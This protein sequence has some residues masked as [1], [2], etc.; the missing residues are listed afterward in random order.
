MKKLFA[1][2][3]L[4]LIFAA[5]LEAQAP[6][7]FSG[8]EGQGVTTLTSPPDSFVAVTGNPGEFKVTLIGGNGV[9]QPVNVS[10]TGKLVLNAW[11]KL[12]SADTLRVKYRIARKPTAYP[13]SW[14]GLIILANSKDTSATGVFCAVTATSWNV[15]WIDFCVGRYT[16]TATPFEFPNAA[17][18]AQFTPWAV[19]DTVELW[20]MGDS[21]EGR[22][23]GVKKM[24]W[25]DSR[26]ASSLAGGAYV[27]IGARTQST[28]FAFDDLTI[29]RPGSQAP[30]P[31]VRDLYGPKGAVS[32]SPTGS[33][34]GK[35]FTFN[36]SATDS[37]GF[38]KAWLYLDST[39]SRS[40]F[41]LLDSTSIQAGG[42]KTYGA[43]FARAIKFLTAGNKYIYAKLQDDTLNVSY[44]DTV[45]IAV[46]NATA[47]T[48]LYVSAY[49]PVWGI[50]Q[51]APSLVDFSYINDVIYFAA[52]VDTSTAPYFG[53]VTRPNDS[54]YMVWGG[55]T[56]NCGSLAYPATPSNPPLKQLIDAVHAAGNKFTLC[57]GGIY[58]ADAG[59]MNYLFADSAKTEAW[60][61]SVAAFC[62][63]WN[64]DGANVDLEHPTNGPNYMRGLRILRRRLNAVIPN[65]RLTIAMG[66]WNDASA[67]RPYGSYDLLNSYIDNAQMMTYDFMSGSTAW[68]N[69]P[70][71]DAPNEYPATLNY[72]S[73]EN[74]NPT[75]NVKTGG[76][77]GQYGWI[78]DGFPAAK[79]SLGIPFY[80]WVAGGGTDLPKKPGDLR[81]GNIFTYG[82]YAEVLTQLAAHP[83]GYHW[84][85]EAGVPFLQYQGT[86][87]RLGGS[88]VSQ[89]YISYDDPQ[90]IPLKVKW[91]A[92]SAI[93]GVFIYNLYDG[94]VNSAPAGQKQPLSDAVKAAVGGGIVPVIPGTAVLLSPSG[95]GID[96]LS[97][98]YKW[99]KATNA[100]SYTLE[101]SSSSAFSAGTVTVFGATTDT[102]LI[103]NAN[104]LGYGQVRYW[105]VTS[106]S[107]TGHASISSASSFTTANLTLSTPLPPTLLKPTANAT[108]ANTTDSLKWS[109]VDSA[110]SYTLQVR[111]GDSTTGAQWTY[112]PA[113][114][115]T[116]YL[117]SNLSNSTVYYWRVS[118]ENANGSSGYTAFRKFTTKAI[119]QDTT[120]RAKGTRNEF[121]AMAAAA[122]DFRTSTALRSQLTLRELSSP[123]QLVAPFTP[124]TYNFGLVGSTFYKRGYDS[125]AV[126]IGSLGGP[127]ALVTGVNAPLSVTNG[128]LSIDQA[129]MKE[130]IAA[131]AN[132]TVTKTTAVNGQ[133]TYT[134]GTTGAATTLGGKSLGQV[135]DS[136][137]VGMNSGG[138]PSLSTWSGFHD[139]LIHHI[140]AIN[141]TTST[142]AG[143]LG[144]M[145][146]N[147]QAVGSGAAGTYG[148]WGNPD[149]GLAD[150]N[151]F[152][153]LYVLSDSNNMADRTKAKGLTYRI[154]SNTGQGASP[155][156]DFGSAL[157]VGW[158]FRVGMLTPST[159][160]S[161]VSI[162]GISQGDVNG[163]NRGVATPDTNVVQIMLEWGNKAATGADSIY[164]VTCDGTNK[165]RQGICIQAASTWY[166]A[167]FT[168][169]RTSVT[170]N[171]YTI[172][173]NVATLAG[174]KTLTTNLPAISAGA[175][176]VF[177]TLTYS[178]DHYSKVT[179]WDYVEYYGAVVR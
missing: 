144:G 34:T 1:V 40:N 160:D 166:R 96:R 154:S 3:I 61:G 54:L 165:T 102:S 148:Q 41:M 53:L 152:G 119:A 156:R 84:V 170:F 109:K 65:A 94:W 88:A 145:S 44:T 30:P 57:V 146:W 11:N 135:V 137:R 5:G 39:G 33:D 176:P 64:I 47:V 21:I 4:I 67:Y 133:D 89:Y 110:A 173:G 28:S 164:A 81:T 27:W 107:T 112:T 162:A 10:G 98:T 6:K 121:R 141:G 46:T 169:S 19:N 17:A 155:T 70:L 76:G 126:A 113:I 105:R 31:S 95:T 104:P 127:P 147:V 66:A 16:G 55:G 131:G 25:R 49:Y 58:G 77:G 51:M 161:L 92:D 56:S 13:T 120:I 142:D 38:R 2:A 108:G 106:T 163:S 151:R 136:A 159:L 85:Q 62:A 153:Y 168:V 71:H 68:L 117:Y 80:S 167:E 8:T 75:G 130:I 22:Y 122:P 45:Q 59:R 115:D 132:V 20:K 174:T 12:W 171:V 143:L 91:A 134:L 24:G 72:W 118:A 60:A 37:F 157:P 114:L 100:V 69:S 93:G 116:V 35:T 177:G 158:T 140:G 73:L 32:S 50:C 82:T 78:H 43:A 125:N 150:T 128:L 18:G 123:D 29:S 14:D 149:F 97:R 111:I 26:Y 99:R 172:S 90:S 103:D 139:D 9:A 83:E 52:A 124:G 42:V 63:R 48:G 7:T 138:P 74:H 179:V 101:V 87:P 23:N 86:Y 178:A 36:L 175:E 129:P 79:M 15:N